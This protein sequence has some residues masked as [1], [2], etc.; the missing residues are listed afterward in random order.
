MLT[1][2]AWMMPRG[3][4]T[5]GSNMKW[6]LW[7]ESVTDAFV[8]PGCFNTPDS[9][10]LTQEAQVMPLIWKKK[11]AELRAGPKLKQKNNCQKL[12]VNQDQTV[13]PKYNSSND[14]VAC[15]GK[16]WKILHPICSAF[17][18][19][20]SC[21]WSQAHHSNYIERHQMPKSSTVNL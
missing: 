15:S 16:N 1:S 14:L 2:I 19:Y 10:E 5:S 8:T 12:G 4:V 3:P 20:H 21:P 6:P 7:V 9:I 13:R 11:T 17:L 18:N